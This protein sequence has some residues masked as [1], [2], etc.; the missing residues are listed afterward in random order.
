MTLEHEPLGL[1]QSSGLPQDLLRDRE[2]AEV[3]RMAVAA[4]S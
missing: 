1:G 4:A 2:L 3:V